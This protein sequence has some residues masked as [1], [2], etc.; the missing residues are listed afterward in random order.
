MD[1]E[2]HAGLA[3]TDLADLG[4]ARV[5][6]RLKLGRLARKPL[7]R[8]AVRIDIEDGQAARPL[9]RDDLA[10]GVH[11]GQTRSQKHSLDGVCT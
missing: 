5:L 11:L 2:R 4:D 3:L 7:P 1:D 10:R 9:R 8:L 6:Q